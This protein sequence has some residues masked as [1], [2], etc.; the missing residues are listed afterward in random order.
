[1]SIS[2][3]APTPTVAAPSPP[4]QDRPAPPVDRPAAPDPAKPVVETPA[5][6]PVVEPV[7]TPAPA[8]VVEPVATPEPA[9]VE[10][11]PVAAAPA[12]ASGSLTLV[13][14]RRLWPDIVEA[15]K[16]MRRLA[17][18]HLTQNCQVI[19]VDG[20]TL[21][22]GF[23]NSGARD[24]FV[25]GGCDG[26]LRQAAVDVVGANWKI[27]TIVDP[28]AQ[29]EGTPTVTK[30]A[31]APAAPAAPEA[32]AAAPDTS[33]PW[34]PQPAPEA[35][36]SAAATAAASAAARE[37]IQQ[38]RSADQAPTQT[39]PD[40]A[41]ADADAHPDDLDAEHQGV[42]AAELLQREL[43]ASMIEEIPHQ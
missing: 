30:A 18:M 11:A 23:A 2:G 10:P 19:A 29:A 20:D 9:P 21:T 31:T 42:S 16:G 43:G 24:S 4:A 7:A 40:W 5:P 32:P 41:T 12:A 14:V 26:V 38:T 39:G 15:T 3:G 34:D 6:A 8:P 28:S 36:D 33:A 27:D 25:S 17:W 35:N 37:A 1:M 22:L 13:D